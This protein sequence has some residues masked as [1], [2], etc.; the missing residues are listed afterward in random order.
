MVQH[1]V[2][3]LEVRRLRDQLNTK[4]DEV[5]SLENRKFQLQMSME[6][7]KKEI[8]VHREVQRAQVRAAEEER[9]RVT[10]ELAERTTRVEKLRAK[11]ETLMKLS[12]TDDD[13]TGGEKSQA[14]FVIQ[15]AQR[16]E[17]LQREGDELDTQIR[18]CE[19]EIRALEN[20]LKHLTVRNSEYRASFQKAD[21][22]SSE[23]SE[24]KALE[25]QVKSAQDILFKRKKEMQRMQTDYEEDRRRLQ[26]VQEQAAHLQEHNEHLGSAHAQ[27]VQELD[28]QTQ[29]KEKLSRKLAKLATEHRGGDSQETLQE[30]VFQTD[31]CADTCSSVLYTLGQLSR[32][33]PEMTDALNQMLAKAGLEVPTRPPSRIASRAGDRPDSAQSDRSVSSNGSRS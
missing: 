12:G 14:F 8:M 22:A 31:S 25:E 11:F 24:L 20:T 3:R 6:E 28:Q 4:A 29:K 1:D 18:K 13:G 15:A 26:Q 2:M 33:F 5:F 32:E 7:R 9:H 21:P 16:R 19:R 30:M 17:E 10:V 27:V 23:A